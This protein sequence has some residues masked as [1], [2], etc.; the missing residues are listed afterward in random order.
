MPCPCYSRLQGVGGTWPHLTV[1]K[2]GSE[3]AQLPGRRAFKEL[4]RGQFGG[5]NTKASGQV[6][7]RLQRLL[8]TNFT[9]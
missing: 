5:Q 9:P 1:G 3:G 4:R 2:L 8:R 6:G 7:V